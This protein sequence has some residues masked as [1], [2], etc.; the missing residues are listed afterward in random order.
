[1]DENLRRSGHIYV[2]GTRRFEA[3]QDEGADRM[4]GAEHDAAE[5]A[6]ASWRWARFTTSPIQV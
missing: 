1:M 5:G 4:I 2:C 3:L 6:L